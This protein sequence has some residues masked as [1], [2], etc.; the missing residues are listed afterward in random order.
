[1]E[2]IDTEICLESGKCDRKGRRIRGAHEWSLILKRYDQSGLTQTAFCAREGLKYG[3]L[4]AWLGRRRKK[5]D[6]SGKG[7]VTSPKFQELSL[8][9]FSDPG[10]TQLEVALPDGVVLRGAQASQLAELVQL[11]RA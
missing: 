3:T 9:G 8:S 1:M 11:L 7:S 4:V 10:N 5:G 6:L 2:S